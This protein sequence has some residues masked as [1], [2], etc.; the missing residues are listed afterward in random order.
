MILITGASGFIGKHLVKSCLDEYGAKSVLVLSTQPVRDCAF[1]LY[2]QYDFDPDYFIRSGYSNIET[3]IHAGAATPKSN[4]QI[5]DWEKYNSN[6]SFTEKL[7][8]ADLPNLKKFI[9][10]STL[11]IYGQDEII[12]EQSAIAPISLYGESKLYCEK[13]IAAWAIAKGKIFQILRIGH[14]Y[15]PGEEVYQKII[16][17]TFKRI[18]ANES[19]KMWGTGN[20]I[21]TFIYIKDVVQAILK[22]ITLNEN[23]G[24]INIVGERQIVIRDLILKMISI[25]GRNLGIEVVPSQNPGRNLIFN[26]QKMRKLLIISETSIDQGLSEEWEYMQ[27][28]N[29]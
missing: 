16:P 22:S 2:K 12:T 26:N 1:L 5:N 27:Q 24:P 8:K 9:Y 14:T 10:L 20:E 18:V 29:A 11:D 15:G 19:P 28:V 6:I 21:R 23:V 13:M 17:E 25:S 4:S 7:L 3:I